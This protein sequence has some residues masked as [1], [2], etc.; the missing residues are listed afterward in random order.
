MNDL[1]SVSRIKGQSAESEL[2]LMQK[3]SLAD[4]RKEKKKTL[5]GAP[6]ESL[7]QKTF[8]TLLKDTSRFGSCVRLTLA[9]KVSKNPR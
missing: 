7:L 4:E 9:F 3:S 5:D 2:L 6:L 1:Q 8:L